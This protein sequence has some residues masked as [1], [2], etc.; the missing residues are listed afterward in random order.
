MLSTAR[1]QP[2]WL[3]ERDRP[4]VIAHRGASAERPENTIGAFRLAE[5]L[6]A[7]AIELDVMRC[8]SGEAVVFHDDDLKRL[9]GRSERV[10]ETPLAVLEEVDLDGERIPTLAQVLESL[11]PRTLV[12]IELKSPERRG[13]GYLDGLRDDG[14]AAEVARVVFERSFAKRVLVSSFD[15][16]QLHRFRKAA[17]GIPIGLLF[18]DEMSRPL[19]NAWAASL[20]KP[21]ALHPESRLVS[22]RAVSE[23]RRARRRVNVWTVDDAH[24]IAF[25]AAVGVSGV[26]TNRPDRARAVVDGKS[27]A[28]A[29]TGTTLR[30]C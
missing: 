3:E 6:G 16:L 9:G 19:R 21:Q 17:R 22:A 25:L 11:G 24:E 27:G 1:M 15:P 7:D 8:G 12:N 28:R 23:W 30:A 2:G 29:G 13:L 26:I 4:L 20:L 18:H 14:L 10:R 5:Q